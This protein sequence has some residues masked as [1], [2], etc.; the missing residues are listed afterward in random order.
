M[1]IYRTLR[2]GGLWQ[3]HND[4]HVSISDAFKIMRLMSLADLI[5]SLCKYVVERT[6]RMV[7]FVRSLTTK[8]SVYSVFSYYHSVLNSIAFI[9]KRK[10]IQRR[11]DLLCR[12]S[13]TNKNNLLYMNNRRGIRKNETKNERMHLKTVTKSVIRTVCAYCVIY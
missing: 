5:I 8:P 2:L 1:K 3:Y 13:W 4:R 11:S 6:H 9:R 7:F 12:L 10:R